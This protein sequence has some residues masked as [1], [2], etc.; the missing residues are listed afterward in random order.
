V[1]FSFNVEDNEVI[2]TYDI[3][4]YSPLEL[5]EIELTFI[6]GMNFVIRP[7]SIVGDVG[8][9]VQGGEKKQIVW[10]IFDDIE[11]LEQSARPVVQIISIYNKPVDPD[12]AVIVD[13]INQQA[14]K[15]YHFKIQRDG[16]MIGGLG[17]GVGAIVCKL[18]ADGYIDDQDKAEDLDEYN[19]AGDNA[20]KYYT[21]SYVLGG[22]SAISIGYSLYQYIRDGRAKK[23]NTS[24]LILP[25]K[26]NGFYLTYSMRF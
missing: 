1:I 16:L 9:D 24:F 3:I 20:Q 7:E 2:I 19:R 25:G 11:R 6:D 17:C 21:I 23:R 8:K 22:A 14:D 26:N 15:R 10:K 5:Y 18:K 13:Q 12:L 4:N